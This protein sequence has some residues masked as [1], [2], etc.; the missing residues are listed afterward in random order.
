MALTAV[1]L[2]YAISV[3]AALLYMRLNGVQ[4]KSGAQTFRCKCGFS[5]T[6]GDRPAHPPTIGDEPMSQVERNRRY[7]EK[8]KQQNQA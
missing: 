5:C 1:N 7:R 4:A 2:K 8:R 6:K 3:L